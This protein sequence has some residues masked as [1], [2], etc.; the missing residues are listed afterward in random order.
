MR[1]FW[2]KRITVLKLVAALVVAVVGGY[3]A[4]TLAQSR[5]PG[6]TPPWSTSFE[7]HL[8]DWDQGADVPLDPNGGQVPVYW[9]I[10]PIIA[11]SGTRSAMFALDGRQDDG[12]IWLTRP[13]SVTSATPV[14]VTVETHIWSRQASVGLAYVALYAG[15][16]PAQQEEEFRVAG[17]ADDHA[18]WKAYQAGFTVTPTEGQVWVAIGISAVWETKLMYAVDD[19]TVTIND[20]EV[21]REDFEGFTRNREGWQADAHIPDDPNRPGRPVVWSI[22]PGVVQHGRQAAGFLVDGAGDDGLVWLTR[23]ISVTATAPVTVT[24]ET[25]V[26]SAFDSFNTLAKVALYAGKTPPTQEADFY[27]EE[28]A[29]DHAG[30]RPYRA[31]FRV[32][33]VNNQVW[34]AVGLSVVWETLVWFPMDDVKVCIDGRCQSLLLPYIA[35]GS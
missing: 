27:Q 8:D 30:W 18:G 25:H 22:E 23:P 35:R 12:T 3:S 34:V 13:I 14:T 16:K 19:V 20:I 31:D 28:R 33:P 11:R 24:V 29:D 15:A 10:A 7:T 21:L 2:F 32:T 6:V 1:E 4:L 26:W 9:D 17:S 5:V